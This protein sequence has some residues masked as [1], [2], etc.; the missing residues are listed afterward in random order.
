[1]RNYFTM[2]VAVHLFLLRGQEILYD[3][4]CETSHFQLQKE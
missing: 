4:L 1:M 2:P 3:S